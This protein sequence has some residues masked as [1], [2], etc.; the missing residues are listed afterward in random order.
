MDA[1]V[2]AR[3]IYDRPA[4]GTFGLK[5]INPIDKRLRTRETPTANDEGPEVSGLDGVVNDRQ[6]FAGNAGNIREGNAPP[7]TG[8]DQRLSESKE[9]VKIEYDAA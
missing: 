5:K 3:A 4:G 9:A 1:L 2:I 8:W 7:P 6:G